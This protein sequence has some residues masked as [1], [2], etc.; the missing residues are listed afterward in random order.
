MS[1]GM[2]S[3]LEAHEIA[4]ITAVQ[5]PGHLADMDRELLQEKHHIQKGRPVSKKTERSRHWANEA[6]TFLD[7]GDSFDRPCNDS[8]AVGEDRIEARGV[9]GARVRRPNGQPQLTADLGSI[10]TELMDSL[11]LELS[12]EVKSGLSRRPL[13]TPLSPRQD[14][15]HEVRSARALHT[16]TGDF[17]ETS[18]AVKEVERQANRSVGGILSIP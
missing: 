11:I 4:T 13:P 7:K 5:G 3:P 6:V 17:A 16:Q 9:I 14:Y 8:S 18:A 10:S 2:L 15:P 12:P 1:L